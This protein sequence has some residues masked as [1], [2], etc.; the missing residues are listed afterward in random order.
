MVTCVAPVI[1]IS[2]RS[3]RVGMR[4][5]L[6]WLAASFC[7]EGVAAADEA[8]RHRFSD[9]PHNYWTREPRD[10][11]S[12]VMARITAGEIK[13]DASSDK[14]QLTSLLQALDVPVS[15]QLLVYSATSFQGG[16]IR[17]ANPRASPA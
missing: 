5:V 1:R 10:A 8:P 7:F 9:A 6:G 15:S 17:P 13:L 16:L 2:A 14:A 4:F 3:W 11:F 12:K